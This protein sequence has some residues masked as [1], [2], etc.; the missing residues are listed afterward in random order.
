MW[1]RQLC[2][3]GAAVFSVVLLSGLT[4]RPARAQ[5][6]CASPVT[7]HMGTTGTQVIE[8]GKPVTLT[9]V[10]KDKHAV[11]GEAA[12]KETRMDGVWNP[13]TAD[14]V[15]AAK[16]SGDGGSVLITRAGQ[17]ECVVAIALAAAP[18]PP[19]APAVGDTG[20]T[21]A[22]TAGSDFTTTYNACRVEGQA[23][24]EETRQQ[25]RGGRRGRP[26]VVLFYDD[27]T[28]LNSTPCF[29]STAAA[30]V[31]DL[32]VAGVYFPPNA[33]VWSQVQFEPCPLES[34]S[35]NI[36]QTESKQP[37]A[38]QAAQ[39]EFATVWFTPRR[40][41]AQAVV[42][43]VTGR[44]LEEEAGQ[45][46]EL[47]R[48]YP[49]DQYQRYRATIQTGVIFS[50]LA[51]TLV[52]ASPQRGRRGGDL[53]RGSRQPRAGVYGGGGALWAAMVSQGLARGRAL[54]RP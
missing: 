17:P 41:Y 40:C 44:T 34:A 5:S 39:A 2:E 49:L 48:S 20:T 28:D 30:A 3:G 18:A 35:P 12:L 50:P 11:T 27:G 31:G 23:K 9:L 21:A 33:H 47:K 6:T 25:M 38:P 45:R 29:V 54:R 36:L 37:Q 52:R 10:D 32:I 15:K 13:A 7:V 19:S 51:A 16:V 42:L 8:R 43:S 26:L 1:S 22:A 24:E 53:Q 46:R 14:S 4:S